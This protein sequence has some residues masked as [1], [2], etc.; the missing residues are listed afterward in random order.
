MYVPA[1]SCYDTERSLHR[2][3]EERERKKEVAEVSYK[4]NERESNKEGRGIIKAI[5]LDCHRSRLI[6]Y[7]ILKRGTIFLYAHGVFY[8]PLLIRFSLIL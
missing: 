1:D 4:N 8:S 7:Y 6:G 5:R 2:A 3:P